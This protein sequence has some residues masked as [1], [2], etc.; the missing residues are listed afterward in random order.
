MDAFVCLDKVIDRECKRKGGAGGEEGINER[1]GGEG[2]GVREEHSEK[3][4][5]MR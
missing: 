1:E 3:T 4:K 5:E 2:E